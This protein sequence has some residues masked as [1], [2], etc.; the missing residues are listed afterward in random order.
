MWLR[1]LAVRHNAFTFIFV[2]TKATHVFCFFY[3]GAVKTC[4]LIAETKRRVQPTMIEQ[5]LVIGH[6]CPCAKNGPPQFVRLTFL[7]PC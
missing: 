4:W 5:S 6:I 1:Y 2:Y 3:R 7:H